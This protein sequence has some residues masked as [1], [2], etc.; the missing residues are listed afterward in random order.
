MIGLP[1]ENAETA[2]LTYPKPAGVVELLVERGFTLDHRKVK[3]N[4][5]FEEYW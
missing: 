4:L 5:H 2:E 1:S 3:G